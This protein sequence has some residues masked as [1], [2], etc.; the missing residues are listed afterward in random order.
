[1]FANKVAKLIVATKAPSW[2]QPWEYQYQRSSGG[3]AC[4]V[5]GPQGRRLLTSG[6]VVARAIHVQVTR[7]GDPRKYNARVEHASHDCDLALLSVDDERFFVGTQA[8]ELGELPVPRA[9]V[10]VWGYPGG[11]EDL[12][13]TEGLIS[14]IEVCGYTH[15]GRALLALQTDA[16]VNPGNSGG[17]VFEGAGARL[18]GVALQ[19]H[20]RQVYQGTH[21]AVPVTVVRQFLDDLAD[22]QVSGVPDLG[23]HWQPLENESL[24]RFVGLADAEDGILVT[25]VVR[26]SAADGVLAERDVV[27][28]IDGV[29]VAR[30]GTVGREHGLRVEFSDVVSRKQVGDEC[31]IGFLRAGRSLSA[32]VTLKAYAALVP[33]SQPARLPSYFIVGGLVFV[34]V[35]KDY[36]ATWEWEKVDHRLKHCFYDQVPTAARDEVVLLSHVLAD[37]VNVG[38]HEAH[39][40]VRAVNGQQVRDLRSAFEAFRSPPAGYHVIELEN[41]GNRLPDHPNVCSLIVLDAH[42]AASSAARLLRAHG[43]PADRSPDLE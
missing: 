32:R 36:M 40:V 42:Q 14:R 9:R 31:A 24:R 19:S 10:T 6:H 43:V 22:G 39:G 2:Y 34:P 25:H 3:S 11:G 17:P 13:V 12:S 21:Y 29:A 26:G 1:M 38:Y 35:T 30:D 23:I 27:T 20:R 18:V 33:L 8:V 37:D 15:S 41:R 16:A 4:V 28:S 5:E 7:A